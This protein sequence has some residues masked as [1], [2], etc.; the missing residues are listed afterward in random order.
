[1]RN[2]AFHL[3]LIP[4][5]DN[6]VLGKKSVVDFLQIFLGERPA[7]DHGTGRCARYQTQ[8]GGKT[9][10]VSAGMPPAGDKPADIHRVLPPEYLVKN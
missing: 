6:D 9:L 8:P 1:M 10:C 7:S 5:T 2:R 4:F 3:Y